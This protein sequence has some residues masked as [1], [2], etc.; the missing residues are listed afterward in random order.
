M[1]KG[2]IQ[3]KC[4]GFITDYL[5]KNNIVKRCIWDANEEEGDVG[6]VLEGVGTKFHMSPTLCNLAHQYVLTNIAIMVP[7][8]L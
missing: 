8:T 4:L 1:A 5:Q 6:E 3:N 2:Y 7:C